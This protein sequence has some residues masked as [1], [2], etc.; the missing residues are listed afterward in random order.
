MSISIFL[1]D[2]LLCEDKGLRDRT[3]KL[4]LIARACAIFKVEKIYIYTDEGGIYEDDF[5]LI[6]LILEYIE[7]PQYLRKRLF[8]LSENLKE[9]GVL[10]PLKTP[11]HKAWIPLSELKIGEIREGVVFRSGGSLWVDLGLD[12]PIK[13]NGSAYEGERVTCVIDKLEP[14][15]ICRRAKSG[16]VKE[17][18]GYRI[19]RVGPIGKFLK[20][21]FSGLKIIASRLGSPINTCFEEVK[22]AIKSS[23]N[24]ALIFGSPKRGLYDILKDESLRPEDVCDFVLNFVPEQGTVSIRTEEAIFI[25]LSIVNIMNLIS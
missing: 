25:S 3:V 23:S 10:P 7:T 14:Y 4:G 20:S 9:V 18:W 24:I 21:G 12:K 2:S 22:S 6:K 1:P 17:Y 16:E 5:K 13:F 19:F 11:H 8:P 15:P